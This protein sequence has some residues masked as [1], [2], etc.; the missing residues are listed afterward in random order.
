MKGA[1]QLKKLLLTAVVALMAVTM[2]VGCQKQFNDG[3]YTAV[4][5]ATTNGYAV[6]EITV[7]GGKISAATLKEIT[8][9]GVEKDYATYPYPKSKEA[10]DTFTKALVGKTDPAKIAVVTG[11][12]HSSHSY[13]QAAERALEKARITPA[14]TTKSFDGTFFGRSPDG[15]RGYALA[16]VT[17]KNDKITEC[18]LDETVKGEDGKLTLKDWA[19]YP[20]QN[21][22]TGRSMMEVAARGKTTV[23]DVNNIQGFTGATHSA[24]A[25]KIAITEAL[26]SASVK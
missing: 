18:Q 23:D 20:Y 25:F 14:V 21:A 12:T 1:P 15:E 11:A 4:S 22:L 3:T 17:I 7:K 26:K 19:N 2:L 13:I 9:M 16:W 24:D 10:N 8:G 5:D 6:A